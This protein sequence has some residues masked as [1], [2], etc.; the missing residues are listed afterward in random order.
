MLF[1]PGQ[2]MVGGSSIGG[3]VSG[4]VSSAQT[5]VD[6]Y[7][8]DTQGMALM[9]S[10]AMPSMYI[11][12]TTTPANDNDTLFTDFD[13]FNSLLTFTSPSP[14]IVR[15]ADGDWK[16]SAHNLYLNSASPA[17]QAVTVVSGL[18]Y[19]LAVTGTVSVTLSG[20][21][22]GTIT[23]AADHEF[24]AASGTLTFGST[25]GSGTV[26]LHLAPAVE[27]YLET[28][29]S[30]RYALPISYDASGVAEGLLVEP[31]ATNLFLNSRSAATQD[32]TVSATAYTLSFFGTGSITLSGTHSET[33]N[34]T[35]ANDRVSTTFTPSAGTLTCTAS[36]TID[37]VQVETG[38]VATSPIVT[39][40]STVTRQADQISLSDSAFP[41]STTAHAIYGKMEINGHVAG[42]LLS[43]TGGTNRV[44]ELY[45]S[46]GDGNLDIYGC[47]GTFIR[48]NFPAIAVPENTEF[49]WASACAA[50]DAN[51]ALNGTD[52]A[53]DTSVTVPAG[54]PDL[55]IGKYSSG[56]NSNLLIK[57][58][59]Y[60]PERISNADLQA[61]TS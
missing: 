34:G 20:A 13:A 16:Y 4:A 54:A 3:A 7:S 2:L 18:S 61:M 48:I 41:S 29:G 8:S 27:T 60:W 33:L 21:S 42:H 25:S 6:T 44:L 38:S 35:G 52:G 5:L 45:D 49:S 56:Q 46:S 17:N 9:F 51:Q 24:T 12:D 11:K 39:A 14:K 15:Q 58:I 40:G 55:H 31:A 59:A 22:T 37:F 30:A 47:N 50:N 23:A 43:L 36:G 26:H 32:I 57:E 53:Q 28:G 10:G 19:R 1:R